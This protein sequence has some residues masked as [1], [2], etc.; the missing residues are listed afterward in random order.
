VVIGSSEV[1]GGGYS[2]QSLCVAG[3]F[4]ARTHQPVEIPVSLQ[5]AKQ[6]EP[7]KLFICSVVGLAKKTHHPSRLLVIV[8]QTLFHDYQE[9]LRVLKKLLTQL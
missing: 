5:R 4:G 6:L 7:T 8:Q 2:W 3:P 1:V 9:S